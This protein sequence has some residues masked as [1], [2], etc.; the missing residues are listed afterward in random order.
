MVTCS[1]GC[2]GTEATDPEELPVCPNG[3]LDTGFGV[4]GLATAG[5]TSPHIEPADAVATGDGRIVVVGR[6]GGMPHQFGLA[7]FLPNG[8][9]DADFGDGGFAIVP[10]GLGLGNGAQPVA[11]AHDADENIIVAGFVDDEGAVV[12]FQPDGTQDTAF[13]GGHVVLDT[14]VSAIAV[15]PAGI[16][17]AGVHQVAP[18]D[19]RVALHRILPDGTPD[20]M[21]GAGGTVVDDVHPGELVELD[22]L[23]VDDDG[24]ILVA[25]HAISPPEGFIVRYLQGGHRDP[26]FGTDGVA[27]APGPSVI[28]MVDDRILLARASNEEAWM[29]RLGVAALDD[30]GDPDTGYGNGGETW[31][32]IE[33]NN[34][35][36][37]DVARHPSGG[38]TLIGTR[39]DLPEF[40]VTRFRAEGSHDTCFAIDGFATGPVGMTVAAI[41]HLNGGTIIVGYDWVD[42]INTRI[43]LTRHLP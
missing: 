10:L 6:S 41:P 34:A 24:R 9:L 40:V 16:V 42:P 38:L 15:T 29:P 19:S 20:P 11:V 13:G 37:T 22:S 28:A 35:G 3:Q 23:A 2:G 17:V 30:A 12:R 39:Y 4:D 32:P 18:D 26:T 21:F 33:A 25:G 5:A 7:R 8:V 36:V 27:P 43:V 31:T 1:L 14:G